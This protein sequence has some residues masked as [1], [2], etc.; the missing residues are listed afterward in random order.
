LEE[1][2]EAM[3]FQLK[4]SPMFHHNGASH[5]DKRYSVTIYLRDAYFAEAY[6]PTE[7]IARLRAALICMAVNKTKPVEEEGLNQ[8]KV[9]ED[10]E[11]RNAG[12]D[13]AGD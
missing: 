2:G 3:G 1:E 13:A 12:A 8:G 6:G 9:H 4:R 7:D 11:L 10:G 5:P